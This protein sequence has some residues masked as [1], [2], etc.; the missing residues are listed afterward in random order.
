MSAFIKFTQGT[1]SV[2][3]DL[4]YVE[5]LNFD[6]N[7]WSTT[8]N[9][10][11]L[12]FTTIYHIKDWCNDM[13]HVWD[14]DIPEG[15]YQVLLMSTKCKSASLRMTNMRPISDILKPYSVETRVQIYNMHPELMCK[16]RVVVDPEM[17]KLL[18]PTILKTI[19]DIVVYDN[20]LYLKKIDGKYHGHYTRSC[21]VL[22]TSFTAGTKFICSEWNGWAQGEGTWTNHQGEITTATFIDGLFDGPGKIGMDEV[23][24]ARGI[25]TKNHRRR[26]LIKDQPEEIKDQPEKNDVTEV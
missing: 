14:V 10:G 16:F 9:V 11:G 23:M 13:T 26:R 24:F 4:I 12:H 1:K 18:T 3:N 2:Y 6:I 22:A 15:E 5:G 7:K 25:F 8:E 20:G 17:I 21:I 19:G